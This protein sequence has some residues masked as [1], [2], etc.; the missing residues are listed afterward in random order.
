[1]TGDTPDISVFRFRFWEQVWYLQ[2]P[3]TTQKE[4]R[5]LKGR[6]LGIAWAT[7]DHMC[8]H[9]VPE[10]DYKRVVARTLVLPRHPDEN[11]PRHLLRHPSDYF[12]PTPK[13]KAPVEGS[14]KRKRNEEQ[15]EPLDPNEIEFP[16]GATPMEDAVR[17]AWLQRTQRQQDLE[18]QLLLP[19]ETAQEDPENV[20]K[21]KRH[22]ARW[23]KSEDRMVLR[24]WAEDNQGHVHR[25][26]FDDL[27]AD[28]PVSLARYIKDKRSFDDPKSKSIKEWSIATLKAHEE[29]LQLTREMREKLGIEA[30]PEVLQRS[31]IIG[32]TTRRRREV[33]PAPRRTKQV[34]KHRKT[35][36]PN[37]RSSSPMGTFKYG[38]YVPKTTEEALEL[39]RRNGN[40]LWRD[41][42]HKELGAIM[43]M[44]TFRVLT[45]KERS[46]FNR[47]M[48]SFAPVR[49]IYDVKADGRRKCRLIIGGHRVS[50]EGFDV[51]ASNMKTISARVLM[52]IASAN[53]YE[54][55]TGDIS[56]GKDITQ[57]WIRDM[58]LPD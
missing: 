44:K 9:V 33:K 50:S 38:V 35:N 25:C 41:A 31:S 34:G 39:D 21:I 55:L 26:T 42:I 58:T 43:S 54:V 36:S 30:G 22:E 2:T 17:D 52:L 57:N 51:Y 28:A 53:K 1:M 29:R 15:P 6:L 47:K 11:A 56:T 10:D 23:D 46:K 40:S 14:K 32:S 13:L 24:F 5:W 45:E 48:S 20:V 4:K 37:R 27:K 7:G 12:F 18:S 49:C 8:Y 19:A 3:Y 16:D